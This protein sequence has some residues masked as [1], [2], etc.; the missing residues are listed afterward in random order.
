MLQP[1][2]VSRALALLILIA[3]IRYWEL[4][5]MLA[6][7]PFTLLGLI[8]LLHLVLSVTSCLGLVLHRGWGFVALYAAVLFGTII[9]GLSFV[10][11]PLDLLPLERR[12]IGVALLNG[13]VLTAGIL[14]HR[15]LLKGGESLA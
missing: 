2:H 8:I 11:L 6:S 13:V 4:V 15:L 14:G 5:P 7:D 1:V 3:M 10:P 12:W 9:L